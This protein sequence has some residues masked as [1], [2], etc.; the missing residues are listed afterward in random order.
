MGV[1]QSSFDTCNRA[2]SNVAFNPILIASPGE[3]KTIYITLKRVE[4][5]AINLGQDNICIFFDMGLLQ[6]VLEMIWGHPED[7]S[8]IFPVDGGLHFLIYASLQQLV[9]CTIS[10]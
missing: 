4:E 10:V 1:F 3:P 5:S 6:K 9:I 7:L 8:G 2:I